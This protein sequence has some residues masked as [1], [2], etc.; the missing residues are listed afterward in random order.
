[1]SEVGGSRWVLG[2]KSRSFAMALESGISSLSACAISLLMW[3]DQSTSVRLQV[4][5]RTGIWWR[6]RRGCVM[7]LF[8]GRPRMPQMLPEQV[9]ISSTSTMMVP[10]LDLLSWS[11][12]PARF[13]Q[14]VVVVGW[15]VVE[16]ARLGAGSWRICDRRLVSERRE[17]GQRRVLTAIK[18]KLIAE[19]KSYG[20]DGDLVER[21]QPL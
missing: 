11:S 10:A 16:L 20:L 2:G 3:G 18:S 17:R 14:T 7:S 5:Y 13:L 4:V 19:C 1:M 21:W 6:G 15:A 8:R 12:I 9:P